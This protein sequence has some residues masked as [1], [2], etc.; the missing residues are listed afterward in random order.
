MLEELSKKEY[1]PNCKELVHTHKVCLQ[2]HY[3][4]TCSEC[5]EVLDED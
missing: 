5:D 4:S 1:C 2:E 3:E